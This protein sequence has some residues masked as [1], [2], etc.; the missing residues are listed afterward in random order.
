MTGKERDL[1]T[2][3][4]I[5]DKIL[6]EAGDSVERILFYGSRVTGKPRASSDFDIL[7]VLRDPVRDWME[8]SLRLSALF[9]DFESAVDVQV[10]GQAEFE[11]A[12]PVVGTTAYPADRYG[13]VLYARSGAESAAGLAT[14]PNLLELAAA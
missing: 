4:R 8:E 11:E 9:D 5:G 2:A 14:R 10:F 12:R 3:R 13:T 6:T 7:V 1:Q